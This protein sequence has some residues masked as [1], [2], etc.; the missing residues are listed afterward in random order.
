M[1]GYL[2][3][4]FYRAERSHWWWVGMRGI[5]R[6]FVEDALQ[7]IP[8]PQ[9]LDVGC[10]TGVLLEQFGRLGTI[11]GV[12]LAAQ[13]V[14]F[15]KKRNST[16]LV[17][18]GDLLHL[19][20]VSQSVDAVF[21]LDVIEHLE[22][23][24][25][26]LLEIRRVLRSNGV[27]LINVPAFQSLWSGKDRANHH[28]RRYTAGT[29]RHALETCGFRVERLTY[30]NATLFPVIWVVRQSQKLAGLA[31]NAKAEYNPPRWVNWTLLQVLRLEKTL[32]QRIDFP[33]GTSV[34]CV[35]RPTR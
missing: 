35:A 19:P 31:W 25:A 1:E 16:A 22:D 15:A 5:W 20:I 11:F 17:V 27:A 7:S 23:D 32:L 24:K 34:T 29:L 26:A 13:A 18:Q 3:D 10:G 2:Y 14:R 4:E 33:F 6:M 21:A 9:L 8:E 12:D 28:Y 30:T